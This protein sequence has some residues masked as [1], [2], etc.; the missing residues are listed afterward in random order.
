[1]TSFIALQTDLTEERERDADSRRTAEW[2][3]GA[4]ASSP[5]A[6]YILTAMRDG[7]DRIADF[8]FAYANRRG[9]ELMRS[10]AEYLVGRPMREMLPLS[11][12]DA[13]ME[14]CRE[15]MATGISQ[16]EE[17]EVVEYP[18][19]MRWL[20]HQIVPLSDGVAIT[21]SSITARK[22]VEL[23]MAQR[24]KMLQSFLGN[25]PGMAWICDDRGNTIA[26]N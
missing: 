16:V 22:L 12:V 18:A 17:F 14:Q 6:L 1:M 8:R 19:E 7:A 11:R 2:F 15:V 26:A 3:E 5:D 23:A 24:E 4:A 25:C 9:G 21:S 13:L 20:R 10:N